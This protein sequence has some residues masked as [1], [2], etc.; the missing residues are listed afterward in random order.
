MSRRI[1]R[2]GFGALLLALGIC[3][4]GG[5]AASSWRPRLGLEV[6]PALGRASESGVIGSRSHWKAGLSVGALGRWEL[7]RGWGI[8][9][10]PGY[11][12][13]VA[14]GTGTITVTSTGGGG[15]TVSQ[16]PFD[17][18]LRFDRIALPVIASFRPGGSAWSIEA[19]LA[20]AWLGHVD[21]TNVSPRDASSA[22]LVAMARRRPAPDAAIFEQVG[23]FDAGD[24]THLFHR[25]D[26]GAAA[27]AGWE[28]PLAGLVLRTRVRW[29]QGLVDVGKFSEPVRLSSISATLGLLW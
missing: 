3:L 6:G 19:G 22:S 4:A 16:F 23:T 21:R 14:R 12:R 11:E 8:E 9:V 5:A 2:A 26:L 25:W 27:G 24:W 13:V 29:R 18:T 15:T 17:Q 7:A 10:V 1:G 20:P 28:R